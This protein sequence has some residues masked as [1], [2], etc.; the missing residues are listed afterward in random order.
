MSTPANS[1]NIANVGLPYFTGTAFQNVVDGAA[2]S[3]VLIGNGVGVVPSFTATPQITG[4]GIG[5]VST[6]TGLTFDGVNTL[7][8]F[9]Q[10]TFTATMDGSV[11]SGTFTYDSFS[12][13]GTY[14][15]IGNVVTINWFTSWS[16]SG[17]ATG[18]L[19]GTNLPFTS[20]ST[21][22]SVIFLWTTEVRPLAPGA[23]TVPIAYLINNTTFFGMYSFNGATGISSGVPVAA[24]GSCS[25]SFSYETA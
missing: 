8:I 10:G 25:A 18:N 17:T 22:G 2:A 7:D 1:L 5:A 6:G 3:T 13:M 4:L 23:A 19:L 16:A 12:Q 24:T 21:G 14:Q 15:K 20:S 11:T 9:E